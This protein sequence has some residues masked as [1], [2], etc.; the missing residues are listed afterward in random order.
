MR[1][2]PGWLVDIMKDRF[3]KGARV[4]AVEMTEEEETPQGT[5]GTVTAVDDDGTI[6]VDWDNG[7]KSCAVLGDDIIERRDYVEH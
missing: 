2:Q 7:S 5:L 1:K 6:F 3:P 4:V